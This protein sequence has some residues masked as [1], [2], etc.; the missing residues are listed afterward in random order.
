MKQ[1]QLSIVRFLKREDGPTA[2]EYAVMLALIIVV[3]IGAISALGGNAS[4]IFSSA[5]VAA[6]SGGDP[7]VYKWSNGDSYNNQTGVYTT[8]GGQTY[9]D[10]PGLAS[11]ALEDGAVQQ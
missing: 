10:P 7:N 4:G 2:V 8:A 5:A 11:L 1:V 6:G 3:C 9:Q